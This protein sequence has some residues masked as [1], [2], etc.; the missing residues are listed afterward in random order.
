MSINKSVPNLGN[1]PN[2]A[3]GPESADCTLKTMS[4]WLWLVAAARGRE[5]RIDSFE[6]QL[7][8]KPDI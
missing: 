8:S 4:L 7:P 1:T 2:L 6:S 5:M 3:V